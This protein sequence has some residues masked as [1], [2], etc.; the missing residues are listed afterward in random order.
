MPLANTPSLF[1]ENITTW[2]NVILPLAIPNLYTYSVP[3]IFEANLQ[4]GCRVEVA[5]KNKKYSAI[6]ATIHNTP[7]NFNCKP[8]LNILDDEPIVYPNQ[9]QL[10]Q[11]MAEYYMCSQG[12]IMAAALPTNFKLSSETI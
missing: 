7:P 12:E 10:W 11:W 2:V 6:I 5:L 1:N 4:V 8:I 3:N 9:L